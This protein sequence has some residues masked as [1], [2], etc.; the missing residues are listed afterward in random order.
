MGKQPAEKVNR[1]IERR[2][3]RWKAVIYV[4][5]IESIK[6]DLA[7]HRR[8]FGIRPPNGNGSRR[9]DFPAVGLEL[10]CIHVVVDVAPEFAILLPFEHEQ[11]VCYAVNLSQSGMKACFGALLIRNCR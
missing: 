4:D 11:G 9:H 3:V 5:L 6:E 8:V 1:Y 7:A 2:E 10:I